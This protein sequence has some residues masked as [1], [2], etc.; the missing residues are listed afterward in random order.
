MP[1]VTHFWIVAT[2]WSILNGEVNNE[3]GIKRSHN[4]GPNGEY[5]PNSCTGMAGK[6]LFVLLASGRGP[7][8]ALASW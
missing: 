4:I 2:L 7:I 8:A 6:C 1:Q 3:I 5:L